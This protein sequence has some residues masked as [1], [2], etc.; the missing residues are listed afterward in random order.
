MIKIKRVFQVLAF[1]LLALVCVLLVN[2]WRLPVLEQHDQTVDVMEIDQ[3]SAVQRLSQAVRFATV[4]HEDTGAID[5]QP[6]IAFTDWLEQVYPNIHAQLTRHRINEHT[7]LFEWTGQ[8]TELAPILLSAHYDVV[9]VEKATLD[10]WVHPPY[11]G[12]VDEAYIWG[13]GTLDNKG[14]LIAMLEAVNQL[15]LN[16]VQ[17]QQTVF[18]AATHDEERGSY[19]GAGGIVQWMQQRDIRPQWSLD[20]GSFVLNG[21]LPGVQSPVA[22]INLAEKGYL[23]LELTV[24]GAGGHSSMPKGLTSVGILAR[25]LDRIQSHPF[26]GELTGVSGDMFTAL[27]ADMPFFKKMLFANTWL[28]EGLLNQTLTDSGAGNAM[29]RTTISPTMFS[30]SVKPNI[31]P[32]QAKA[33]INFRLHPNDSIKDVIHHV[34]QVANDDRVMIDVLRGREASPVASQEHAGFQLLTQVS[35]QIFNDAL[36]VPGLTI[37]ATDSRE[38]HKVAHHAYRFNP[39]EISKEDIACFHGKNERLSKENLFNAIEFYAQVMRF[40]STQQQ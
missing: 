33:T 30:G 35:Q 29:L 11:S 22:S 15:L 7:L 4:S 21:I 13:R 17:P 14:A 8:Q 26:S 39:M 5:Y 16:G 18:I 40:S 36:V 38:Y 32:A 23:N 1:S 27:A 28:F 31:L 10:E 20:E 3:A 25:A 12:H 19:E 6:F 9:P 34:T 37:G 2:T 24:N